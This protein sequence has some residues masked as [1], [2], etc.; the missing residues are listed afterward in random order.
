[1]C[2]ATPTTDDGGALNFEMDKRAGDAKFQCTKC[3]I[4]F[5]KLPVPK[6]HID[7]LA[8]ATGK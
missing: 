2:H 5:G 8:A 3:H 1:M 4:V 7:A 6:T